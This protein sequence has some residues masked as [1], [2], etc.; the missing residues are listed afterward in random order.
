MQNI[1]KAIFGSHLYGTDTANSDH[2]YK[3][4]FLPSKRDCFLNRISNTVHKSTGD[5]NSKNTKDDIDEEL[6]SIQYFLKLAV[7]GEMIVIDLLHVPSSMVLESSDLWIKLQSNRS[8]FY[9]KNLAGYLG[10]IRKQ[11]AKYGIKGSRLSAME[12]VLKVLSVY[13]SEERII[14]A[15]EVLPQNE[16]CSFVT[17][18]KEN[19]WLHYECCGKQLQETM[20]VGYAV[21]I[22]QKTYDRYGERA[23]QAKENVG[24]DFKAVSHAFRAGFQLKEIYETGDLK[25]PLKD[26]DYIRDIKTGKY[27]YANDGIGEKLEQLLVEVESL[28]SKSNLPEKVD[29]KWFDSFVLECYEERAS[30]A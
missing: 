26:A 12:E 6:Y 11:T 2:D 1:V 5:S 8:R 10:Y 24:I 21:D 15:W 14:K 30:C 7:N 17:N 3:G 29:V 27:H 13:S 22:I 16:Y 28:S 20:S 19:R 9:S 25:Y 4:I 18:P 23:Q